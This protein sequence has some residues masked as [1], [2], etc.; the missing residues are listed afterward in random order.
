[1]WLAPEEEYY[2]VYKSDGNIGWNIPDSADEDMAKI[3]KVR[4]QPAV[5]TIAPT[6][7]P[8]GKSRLSISRFMGGVKNV[9]AVATT[10]QNV[11]NIFSPSS[12]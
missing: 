11:L 7:P 4:Q 10:A 9:N 12:P 3:T 6:A 5:T 8:K 1:M 2:V